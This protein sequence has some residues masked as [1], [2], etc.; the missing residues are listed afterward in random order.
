MESLEGLPES[1]PN[2]ESQNEVDT[3]T[4][5]ADSQTSSSEQAY[6]LLRNIHQ[7]VYVLLGTMHLGLE[8]IHYGHYDFDGYEKTWFF[9]DQRLLVRDLLASKNV[10]E[11]LNSG[12]TSTVLVTLW[13]SLR[14]GRWRP[15]GYLGKMLNFF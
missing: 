12:A 8:I 14:N 9:N 7:D 11:I 13:M 6:G 4:K 10:D 5:L 1:A 15:Y 2:R 3:D